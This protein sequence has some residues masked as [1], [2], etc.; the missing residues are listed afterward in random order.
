M[1]KIVGT[2]LLGWFLVLGG[3]AVLPKH[4]SSEENCQKAGQ[5]QLNKKPTVTYE[6]WNSYSC[7]PDEQ[8]IYDGE[9]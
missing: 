9:I 4:Y 1:K 7:I 8:A 3:K 2:A 5:Y 6:I